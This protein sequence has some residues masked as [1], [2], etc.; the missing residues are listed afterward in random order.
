MLHV[1]FH[2]CSQPL[3]SNLIASETKIAKNGFCRQ[4]G[5]VLE[6][7]PCITDEEFAELRQAFMNQSLIRDGNIFLQSSPQELSAFTQFLQQ[8]RSHP[9]TVVFDGLNIAYSNQL[10]TSD[11]RS[12]LVGKLWTVVDDFGTLATS[13]HCSMVG[14]CEIFMTYLLVVIIKSDKTGVFLSVSERCLP[15]DV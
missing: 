3:G 11:L 9:F 2:Y 15:L 13:F 1:F 5:A 6:C 7:Q 12:R 10:H 8:A 14:C 4:C